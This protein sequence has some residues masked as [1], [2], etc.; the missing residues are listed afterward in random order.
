PFQSP[1]AEDLILRTSD[2]ISLRVTAA[3]LVVNSPYMA[4]LLFNGSPGETED[5]LPVFRTAENCPTICALLH[6]CYPMSIPVKATLETVSAGW[7]MDALRKY[8]MRNAENRLRAT[9]AGSEWPRQEPLKVYCI[10]VHHGWKDI[11]RM[12]AWEALR[13]PVEQWGQPSQMG[14]ITGLDYARLISYVKRSSDAAC[15]FLQ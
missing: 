3:L 7:L 8:G 6:L 2:G 10:A 4:N 1:F 9:I 12:A 15:E 14:M 11:A 13:I 5:G